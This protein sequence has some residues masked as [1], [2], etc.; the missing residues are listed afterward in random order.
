MDLDNFWCYSHNT[1]SSIA[2]PVLPLFKI[3]CPEM[4]SWN[5]RRYP[6]ILQKVTI[7]YQYVLARILIFRMKKKEKIYGG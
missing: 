6:E 7:F 2:V 5:F 1:A 4:N 3:K